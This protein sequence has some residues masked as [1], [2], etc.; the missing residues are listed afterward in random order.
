[1]IK[2]KVQSEANDN[3]LE[4]IR[5]AIIA[6]IKRL[7]IG[8]QKTEKQIKL[9]EQEYNISSEEFLREYTAEDM[10]KGDTEYIEWA[11]ELKLKERIADD[12]KRLKEI[13]Y[14]AQ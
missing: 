5:S 10:K 2:L 8:L 6:E 13:E 12:L 7:E 1:M 14:V 9:F 4:I 11:G 3:I